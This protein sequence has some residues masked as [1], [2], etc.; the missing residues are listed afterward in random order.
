MATEDNATNEKSGGDGAKPSPAHYPGW[1]VVAIGFV[2]FFFAFA[3]SSTMPFIYDPVMHEFGWTRTQATLIYTYQS[4]TGA[5]IALFIIGPAIERFGLRAVQFF[6]LFSVATGMASFA[7]VNSLWTFY[8]AGFLIGVGQGT[9]LITIKV[10]VSRWFMRNL[11]LA[12]SIAIAGS[13]L[14]GIVFPWVVTLL[15]PV[16]GWRLTFASLSLGVYIVCLPLCLLV[17]MNPTEEDVL[18]ESM[19]S[20]KLKVSP[21]ALRAAEL[22]MTFRQVLRQPGFLCIMFG[23]ILI[24]MVDQGLFQ[25][26]VL[27][28]E[29]DVGLSADVTASAVSVVFI[30][31]FVAKFCAGRFFD[32][33]SMKGIGFWYVTVAIA[34]LLALP[35]QGLITVMIFAV[36]RGVVHGGLVTESPIVAKHVYGPRL[37]NRVLPVLNGF[38]ALGSSMGPVLLAVIADK[39][40]YKTGFI[41][42]AAIA[43]LAAF[44]ISRAAPLYRNRLRA[45]SVAAVAAG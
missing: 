14:G 38:F 27:Y 8:F 34:T 32:K 30:V 21:D 2:L 42:F 31:G 20:A 39:A 6:M 24:A 1:R 17:H 26:T 23:I 7:I 13:S 41:I 33:T 29:H 18:P 3:A 19:P 45:A 28:L 37:M 15:M 35:V 25:H 40:G 12:G 36:A 4:G 9:T 44:L 16:I 5:L 10:L 11:G 43:M 22:D